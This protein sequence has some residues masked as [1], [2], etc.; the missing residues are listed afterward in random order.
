MRHACNLPRGAC[1]HL[2]GATTWL[3]FAIDGYFRV[4]EPGRRSERQQHRHRATSMLG[5]SETESKQ[6]K[7]LDKSRVMKELGLQ[8]FYIISMGSWLFLSK[9]SPIVR[10]KTE[11][12]KTC[13][14]AGDEQN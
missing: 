2:E 5:G 1:L 4:R 12:K 9:R 11:R 13:F 14:S 10:E 8:D 6:C 7:I 3:C